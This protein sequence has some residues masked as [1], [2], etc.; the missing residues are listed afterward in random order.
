MPTALTGC[1]AKVVA[2]AA[3]RLHFVEFI[4]SENEGLRTGAE[5]PSPEMIKFFMD[6]WISGKLKHRRRSMV[7]LSIVEDPKLGL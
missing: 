1:F 6:Y 2:G 3:L 7:G 5:H 4:L